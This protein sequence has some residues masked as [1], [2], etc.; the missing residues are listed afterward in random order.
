MRPP[1]KV[2]CRQSVGRKK[3]GGEGKKKAYPPHHTTICRA[4][5][6]DRSWSGN[7]NAR[8]HQRSNAT[9]ASQQEARCCSLTTT[10]AL[11]SRTQPGTRD[12]PFPLRPHEGRRAASAAG[13]RGLRHV[14]WNVP[15]WLTFG[16]PRQQTTGLGARRR[17]VSPSSNAAANGE[18][19]HQL[20]AE[21]RARLTAAL[22]C[23]PRT[24]AISSW[25][26][27]C[28]IHVA[29]AIRKANAHRRLGRL[30]S[31][32]AARPLECVGRPRCQWWLQLAHPLG[33]AALAPT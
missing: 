21:T 33:E 15:G 29:Y 3:K 24:P 27:I 16:F 9:P 7:Q 6:P 14:S 26:L 8:E 1:H 22:L 5:R 30:L 28:G 4:G 19:V 25:V 17:W 20:V 18:L 12:R 11:P 31:I 32:P 13:K 2:V 10:G 23:R